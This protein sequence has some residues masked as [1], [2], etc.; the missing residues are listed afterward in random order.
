[1]AQGSTDSA[2]ARRPASTG[3][4]SPA[5]IS[6]RPAAGSTRV[7]SNSSVRS[8]GASGN[9]SGDIAARTR[10]ASSSGKAR[11]IIAPPQNHAASVTTGRVSATQAIRGSRATA[12]AETAKG[13]TSSVCGQRAARP[14]RAGSPRRR[15]DAI[16]QVPASPVNATSRAASGN[17]ASRAR[18]SSWSIFADGSLPARRCAAASVTTA[19]PMPSASQRTNRTAEAAVARSGRCA[20]SRGS[21]R[22]GAMS[23]MSR[24]ASGGWGEGRP[25]L[26]PEPA[27]GREAPGPPSSQ[28]P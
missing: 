23:F 21:R 16:T 19:R 18:T 15:A 25:G 12:I 28:S 22:A 6:S 7:G 26:C 24:F 4:P 14:T 8:A 3:A 20:A 17:S 9:R 5:R 2:A 27:K 13:A 1:M 10:S 11:T